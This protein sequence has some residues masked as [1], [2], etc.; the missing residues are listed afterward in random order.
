MILEDA[1]ARF[2]YCVDDS[3]V[4]PPG[5]VFRFKKDFYFAS[6][7]EELDYALVKL[8]EALLGELAALNTHLK[9]LGLEPISEK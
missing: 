7:S 5:R 8:K 2:D 4:A 6:P 3:G 1:L 9:R